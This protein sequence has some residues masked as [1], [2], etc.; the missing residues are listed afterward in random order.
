MLQ[1]S[2]LNSNLNFYKHLNNTQANFENLNFFENSR[3]WVFKK[4]YFPNQQQYNNIT[5]YFTPAVKDAGTNN[6][7]FKYTSINYLLNSSNIKS[8]HT[9]YNQLTPS[10]VTRNNHKLTDITRSFNAG[11]N[12]QLSNV[13]LSNLD[14]LSGTG[15]NFMYI[16]TSNPQSLNTNLNYFSNINHNTKV[17]LNLKDV[18]FTL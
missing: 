2:L 1:T 5:N 18:K 15:L 7:E 6:F 11:D 16:L 9:I 8:T 14:V 12:S 10:L 13:N 17:N 3:L 4:Y